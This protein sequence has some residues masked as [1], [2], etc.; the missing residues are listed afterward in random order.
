MRQQTGLVLIS[1]NGRIVPE[2]RGILR[3]PRSD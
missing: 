2:K 3:V 1:Y